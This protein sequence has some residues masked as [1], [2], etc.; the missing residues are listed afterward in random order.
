VDRAALLCSATGAELELFH[1]VNFVG[2]DRLRRLVPG[3][4]NGLEQRAIDDRSE[5]LMLLG[6]SLSELHGVQVGTNVDAGPAFVELEK[7]AH[8][9]SADLVVVGTHGTNILTRPILGSTASWMAERSAFPVLVVKQE[10]RERYRN[11]L[12]P[13]DFSQYS[14][15]GLMTALRVAPEGNI[16][17]MHAYG[18]PFEGKLR[19]ARVVEEVLAPFLAAAKKKV[20]EKLHELTDA[21]G[22]APHAVRLLACHGEVLHQILEQEE[23]RHCD[24]IAMGRH[25]EAPLL[26]RVFLGSVTKEVLALSQVDVL[27]TP[28][29]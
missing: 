28:S 22:L 10:P 29:P 19:A 14:L 13:V 27:V 3:I 8:E 24:L 9:V 18:V 5:E 7:R 26:E 20:F 23:I 25:G 16:L 6:G 12:V 4:P 2:L 21:A 11:V 1:A 17:L 15:P